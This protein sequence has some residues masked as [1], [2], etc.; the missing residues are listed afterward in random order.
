M[1]VLAGTGEVARP[2]GVTPLG[3]GYEQATFGKLSRK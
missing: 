2:V 3:S 1:V